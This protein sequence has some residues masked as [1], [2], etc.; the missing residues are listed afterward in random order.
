MCITGCEGP[1]AN[2][3]GSVQIIGGSE[4]PEANH[5]SLREHFLIMRGLTV[6]PLIVGV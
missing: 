2:H 1:I 6:P 5:R 4:F 3:K